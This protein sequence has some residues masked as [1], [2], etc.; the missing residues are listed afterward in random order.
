MLWGSL[1]IIASILPLYFAGD[2]FT[3]A[4]IY[5]YCKKRPHEIYTLF[6]GFQVK[7]INFSY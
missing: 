6:F 3:F 4:L 1:V 7:S 5:I 2:A